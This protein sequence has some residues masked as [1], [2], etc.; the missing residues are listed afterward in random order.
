MGGGYRQKILYNDA[1]LWKVG[2]YGVYY[3]NVKEQTAFERNLVDKDISRW[4]NLRY[5]HRRYFRDMDS[6]LI[7]TNKALS[8]IP[9]LEEAEECLQRLINQTGATPE[10]KN[11][12]KSKAEKLIS[13]DRFNI[14]SVT[15]QG[16]PA[17]HPPKQ[18]IRVHPYLST[19]QSEPQS[20]PFVKSLNDSKVEQTTS[21]SVSR[22]RTVMQVIQAA[23]D[24]N[25]GEDN[26]RDLAPRSTNNKI[27]S[28]LH[29]QDTAIDSTLSQNALIQQNSSISTE[30]SLQGCETINKTQEFAQNTLGGVPKNNKQANPAETHLKKESYGIP[31]WTRLFAQT[32]DQVRGVAHSTTTSLQS[33]LPNDL[34]SFQLNE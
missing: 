15:I 26:V 3:R 2:Y 23:L 1:K 33:T 11:H 32:I 24:P 12:P 30:F 7:I 34:I 18:P 19:L 28:L 22:V 25:I 21:D 6:G 27:C 14:T 5:Q 9:L 31:E 13:K 29:E 4:R 10:T 16:I 20:L 8:I 17:K